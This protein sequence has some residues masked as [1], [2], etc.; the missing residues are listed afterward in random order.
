MYLKR[1]W[2]QN[3]WLWPLFALLVFTGCKASRP[4]FNPNRKF[5]REALQEDF[6]FLRGALEQT[7]PSLNW[8]TSK[9]SLNWYFEKSFSR[10]TDS[11][12]ELQ[13][14]NLLTYAVSKIRCGH[15][16]VKPSKAYQRFVREHPQPQFPLS[17][18]LWPNSTEAVVMGNINRRDSIFKRGMIVNAI[19]G[20]PVSA[21]RDSFFQHLTTDGFSINHKYQSLS[22][23]FAGWHRVIF[24][25]QKEYQVDYTDS[26]GQKRTAR[27]PLYNP[28]AD[29]LNRRR[30]RPPGT[31]SRPRPPLTRKEARKA[32]LE[33]VR[34][35]RIDT[36]GQT[37]YMIVNSFGSGHKLRRFFRRSFKSLAGMP[38][39]SNLVI[40]LR[41]NGGGN[42]GNSNL[43]TRFISDRPF[44]I[45][46]SLFAIS[47][48][49]PYGRNIQSYFANRFF[50]RF[51]TA[52]RKDGN[53]H[54]GYFERHK[55][56]PKKRNHYNGQVY[57]ITGGDS[58]SAT[59]LFANAVRGQKNITI[60]GEET[61][62]GSYGNTAF[63]IP[64]LTLPNTKMRVRLPYFRLVMKK[65]VVKDGRGIIPDITVWP[66][67]EALARFQDLKM[68]KVK[69]LIAARRKN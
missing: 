16:S 19:N 13:Y 49:S 57:L 39:I 8:Y 28:A 43:L 32:R 24:G 36:V 27:I 9:D 41:N 46:D 34:S 11:M 15:T 7:H 69:A 63:L 14:W 5:S 65:D 4:A 53:Y 37:A 30:Q 38:E 26:L 17:L 1:N 55:F 64:D 62:G 54:F 25:L 48:T 22:N 10:I 35:L 3:A 44:K 29:T 50:M 66:T 51:F 45:A 20:I 40:E 31:V 58:F 2:K 18:K 42:V 68:E 23:N 33:S 52:R 56:Y 67:A 6:R 61:G 12:T 21:L 59:T 47:R 60:I